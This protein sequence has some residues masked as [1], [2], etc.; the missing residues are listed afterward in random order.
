MSFRYKKGAWNVIDD[1]TGFKHKSTDL[2]LRW[3]G[4][5]VSKEN[6][7][8]RH[9]QELLRARQDNMSVPFTRPRTADH[10]TDPAYSYKQSTVNVSS[11]NGSKING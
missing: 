4:L 2:R 9:P 1:V 7:E 3:D 5:Y 6:W 8:T 10:F 11:V